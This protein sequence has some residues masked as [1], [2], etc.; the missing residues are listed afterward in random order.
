MTNMRKLLA[1]GLVAMV[2]AAPLALA[3]TNPGTSPQTVP[4][5]GTGRA[6]FPANCIPYGAGT[7]MLQCATSVP[8]GILVIDPSGVP[9]F[10]QSIVTGT[11]ASAVV[12]TDANFTLRDDANPS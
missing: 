2:A 5:G 11:W 3:Q 8:N 4:K 1:A 10:A 7:S 12:V 6:S 9:A